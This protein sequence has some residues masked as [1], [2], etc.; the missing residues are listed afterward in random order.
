MKDK[1]VNCGSEE[2]YSERLCE[3]CFFEGKESLYK[4]K[5]PLTLYSCRVCESIYSI[6]KLYDVS[7]SQYT[8]NAFERLI[9]SQILQFWNFT[10]KPSSLQLENLKYHE[11]DNDDS[12]ILLKGIV[13]IILKPNPFSPD[14]KRTEDMEVEFKWG[15]C[16]ECRNRTEGNYLS[17]IQLRIERTVQKELLESW[18][19]SIQYEEGKMVEKTNSKSSLFKIKDFKNGFDFEFRNRS[20]AGTISRSFVKKYGGKITH[21]DEFAGFDPQRWREFP[22]KQVIRI[23]LPPFIVGDII[24]FDQNYYQLI[25]YRKVNLDVWDYTNH[26]LKTI[27]VSNFWRNDVI[28]V[29]EDPNVFEFQII[30][31]EQDL[32]QI[33]DLNSFE[34]YYIPSLEVNDLTEGSSFTG[35]IIEDGNIFRNRTSSDIT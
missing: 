22:R 8:T 21:T 29:T 33:M 26:T 3:S 18:K 12:K 35:T 28:L 6:H 11:I 30:N 24:S 7:L 13:K 5:I 31:F 34:Y 9:T 2:I 17:K 14:I 27:P 32:A 23:D 16:S 20:S 15:S 1:C 4:P 19:A 25:N 10:S